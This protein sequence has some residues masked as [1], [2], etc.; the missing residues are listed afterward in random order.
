MADSPI[1][2][3]SPNTA[4]SG[5]LSAPRQPIG[6]T[7]YRPADGRHAYRPDTVQRS[8]LRRLVGS[9]TADRGMSALHSQLRSLVASW[10][11]AR[12]MSALHKLIGHVILSR[13]LHSTRRKHQRVQITCTKFFSKC[14]HR[15]YLLRMKME[16][17]SK[18][19]VRTLSS[20]RAKDDTHERELSRAC[21]WAF[22]HPFRS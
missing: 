3:K 22:Q 10:T 6:T 19:P 21:R 18:S 20:P 17:K 15:W 16:Y 14:K 11:A 4:R 9:W 13:S 12:G 1:G 8:P 5:A 2:P 7:T